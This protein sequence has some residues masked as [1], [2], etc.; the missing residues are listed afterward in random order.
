M[1][2]DERNALVATYG[3]GPRLLD[4]ALERLPR[5]MWDFKPDADRWSVHEIVIHLADAEAIAFARCRKLIAEPSATVMTYNQ[6]I[7]SQRLQYG[8]R[9]PDLAVNLFRALRAS[10][11][12][13]LTSLSSEIWTTAIVHHPE[14]GLITLDDWLVGSVHHLSIHLAQMRENHRLH[15]GESA[16]QRA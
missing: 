3:R 7:W 2:S 5:E 14:R 12:E 4:E 1:T 11:H 13:L 16:P 10:T 15:E 8:E 9:D 6:D